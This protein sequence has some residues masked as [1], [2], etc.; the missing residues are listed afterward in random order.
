PRHYS[1][2]P[3]K[4][5]DPTGMFVRTHQDE[6]KQKLIAEYGEL[7]DI[8]LLKKEG[9]LH[10]NENIINND[11]RNDFLYKASINEKTNYEYMFENEEYSLQE[12]KPIHYQQFR[13]ARLMFLKH[14]GRTQ[15][16]KYNKKDSRYY[17][18][19]EQLDPYSDAEVF[20]K[21]VNYAVML[22]SYY[23]SKGLGKGRVL[24]DLL[25]TIGSSKYSLSKKFYTDEFL[26]NGNSQYQLGLGTFGQIGFST[27]LQENFPNDPNPNN[28]QH[29]LLGIYLSYFYGRDAAYMA[30]YYHETI[31]PIMHRFLRRA[32][33]PGT[34]QDWESTKRA[35]RLGMKLRL[36]QLEIRNLGD[37]IY[38]NITK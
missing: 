11:V 20:R 28:V 31:D 12:Y 17:N 29:H 18:D 38:E 24:D 6:V 9:I 8:K 4:Y 15:Y 3:L 36:N 27:S 5:T 7:I 23:T 14:Y 26:Q 37:V 33:A 19:K 25:L 21:V 1:T 13:D 30:G 10:F 22:N 2:R 32:A 34:L 16:Y 35:I